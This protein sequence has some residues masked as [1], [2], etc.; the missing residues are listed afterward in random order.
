MTRIVVGIDPSSVKLAM[1]AKAVGVSEPLLVCQSRIASTGHG[2]SPLACDAAYR[3]IPHYLGP[4]SQHG[5]LHVYIEAPVVGRGVRST[6]VQAFVSGA[7]QASL[8]T[9]TRHVYLVYPSAWKKAVI[10]KGSATKG[11][12]ASSIAALWPGAFSMAAGD[13]DIVDS[14]AICLYAE[15]RINRTAKLVKR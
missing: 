2:G 13:Q 10:G 14:A 5:S 7:I 6:L 12:V 3:S 1:V 4:L 8:A 9:L 15:Q 11:D